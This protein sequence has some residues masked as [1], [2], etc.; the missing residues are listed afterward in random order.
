MFVNAS[1]PQTQGGLHTHMTCTHTPPSSI[2]SE[3]CVLSYPPLL[4]SPPTVN[5]IVKCMKVKIR[6]LLQS[7]N[8][9]STSRIKKEEEDV[10]EWVWF[11]A[12]H[13]YLGKSLHYWGRELGSNNGTC[14]GNPALGSW[15]KWLGAHPSSSS[16]SHQYIGE[17]HTRWMHWKI[18]GSL[19]LIINSILIM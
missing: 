3:S 17:K 14:N 16:T 6:V 5:D 11:N 4:P 18:G 7:K 8:R 2:H 15:P 19:E 10:T 13:V 12:L 1:W 9:K